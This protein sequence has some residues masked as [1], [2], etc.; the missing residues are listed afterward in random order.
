MWGCER[1]TLYVACVGS[2]VHVVS[3]C[4][5]AEDTVHAAMW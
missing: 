3:V 1:S 4:V 2:V 5:V